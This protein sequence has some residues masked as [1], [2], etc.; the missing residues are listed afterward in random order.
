MYRW[1]SGSAL[2]NFKNRQKAPGPQVVNQELF[3][4]CEAYRGTTIAP[5]AFAILS[6]TLLSGIAFFEKMLAIIR[7]KIILSPYAAAHGRPG[8][9]EK[10]GGEIV[11]TKR[12][13]TMNEQ[14]R[15]QEAKFWAMMRAAEPG[16]R[17]LK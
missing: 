7:D 14:A 13:V 1:R 3:L 9:F 6:T 8:Q 15:R 11:K 2:G 4:C 12:K 17:C 16:K 5:L 10:K